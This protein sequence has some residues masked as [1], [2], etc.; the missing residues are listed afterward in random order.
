MKIVIGVLSYNRFSLWRCTI[1]SL[2][3]SGGGFDLLLYDNGSTDVRMR[4]YIQERGGILNST[5]NH[6]IG[7]GFRA[8]ARRALAMKPDIVVLSGDDYEYRPGWAARLADFWQA[9][10]PEVAICTLAVEPPYHWTPILE[11][12]GI[13]GEVVQL[14]RTV[15]GANWSFRPALWAEIDHLV[16][17]NSHKYDHAVCAHLRD[18]GRWLCSVDLAVHIGEGQRSW[19]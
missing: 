13:G 3:L 9:A 18:A 15:P 14:R 5:P 17:D 19:K 8:L 10:P 11:T 1:K 16:P 6:T 12:R 2:D 7:H 4:Q